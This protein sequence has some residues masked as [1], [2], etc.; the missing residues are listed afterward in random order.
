MATNDA[1]KRG[2]EMADLLLIG[3]ADFNLRFC[4]L[5][6]FVAENLLA[7]VAC[8]SRPWASCSCDP[9]GHCITLATRIFASE[10]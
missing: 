7:K 9:N 3:I 8:S 10:I 5:L 2:A 1:R 6:S 4:I